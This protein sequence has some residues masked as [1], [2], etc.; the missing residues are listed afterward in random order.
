VLIARRL[1]LSRYGVIGLLLIGAG[2]VGWVL[3][4]LRLR[5][6]NA[7]PP[8]TDLKPAHDPPPDA[9]ET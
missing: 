5:P 3:T 9:P 6:R 7:E 4:Q 8:W 2:G 1:P